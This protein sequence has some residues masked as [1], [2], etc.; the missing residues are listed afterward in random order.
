MLVHAV[1]KKDCNNWF[2]SLAAKL[3]KKYFK[4]K[5][6]EKSNFPLPEMKI[7]ENQII[8]LLNIFFCSS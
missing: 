1:L 7:E 6:K 5:K 3:G 8:L 4:V 2:F